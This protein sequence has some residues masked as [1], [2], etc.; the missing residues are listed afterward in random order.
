LRK[1][2]YGWLI[3]TAALA[4]TFSAG[5]GAWFSDVEVSAR[6]TFAAG[7]WRGN[8]SLSLEPDDAEAETCES[9]VSHSIRVLNTAQQAR[10]IAVN[11]KLAVSVVKGEEYVTDDVSCDPVVGDIPAGEE[12]EFPLSVE[13]DWGDDAG[14]KEVKLRI[15][16][17]GEDNWP[18]HNVGRR[19]H[20][21]IVCR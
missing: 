9:P 7:T 17:V 2:T 14:E 5:L 1:L 3:L 20:F 16:V 19:A 6:N 12:R 11:V 21:T 13:L 18:E 8:P 15:E 10:D 4:I